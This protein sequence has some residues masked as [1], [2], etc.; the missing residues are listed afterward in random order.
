MFEFDFEEGRGFG[1]VGVDGVL[2]LG[3]NLEGVFGGEDDVLSL[4]FHEIK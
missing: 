1:R 4:V 2:A 3:D